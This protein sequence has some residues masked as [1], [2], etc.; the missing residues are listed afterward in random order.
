M[1]SAQRSSNAAIVL[2]LLTSGTHGLHSQS[3]GHFSSSHAQCGQALLIHLNALPHVPQ[4]QGTRLSACNHRACKV[5]LFR[6][7]LVPSFWWSSRERGWAG[8][9]PATRGGPQPPA[10]A[11][12][13]RDRR[14]GVTH[15]AVCLESGPILTHAS[16]HCLASGHVRGPHCAKNLADST[17]TFTLQET[18]PSIDHICCQY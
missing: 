8:G 13:T 12:Q 15:W 16:T 4:G 7:V 14:R 11:S 5:L 1:E 18:K 17:R 10:R 9:L 3:R 6:K 2:V